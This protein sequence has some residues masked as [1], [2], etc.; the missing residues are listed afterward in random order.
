[1][2]ELK[3]G[4]TLLDLALRACGDATAAWDI[5]VMNGI[6]ITTQDVSVVLDTPTICNKK[7]VTMYLSNGIEPA[8]GGVVDED[9]VLSFNNK[10]IIKN[11]KAIWI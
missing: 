8:T 7:V 5:A 1:M 3:H 10:V 11:N 4:Q 2:S 6:E 9:R